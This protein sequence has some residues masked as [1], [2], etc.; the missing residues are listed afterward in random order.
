MEKLIDMHMHT[1]SSDGDYTADSLIKHAI[2][3]NVGTIAITDHDTI[4][5]LKSINKDNYDNIN[6]IDGIE[7]SCKI[8]KGSLHMLGYNIDINS[9]YLSNKIEMLNSYSFNNFIMLLA[10]IKKDY[11]LE[12]SYNDIMSILEKRKSI[13][14][15]DIARLCVKYGY[16]KTIQEGFDLYLKPA[17]KIIN[18]YRDNLIYEEAIDIIL[19]SGGIPVL[20]HPKTL[21][22]NEKELLLFVKKLITCGLQGIEVY[23]SSHNEEEMSLYLDI[24]K[25]YDLLISGGS[26]FH[27]TVKP[28]VKLGTGINNNLK[29]K[30]LSI[31]DYIK[32]CN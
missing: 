24:A 6:I 4:A 31:L 29:I 22:M 13:G 19:N 21:K 16:T 1:N 18:D 11:G 3:N 32:K 10:Q 9:E 7:L 20:A 23:H 30:Q 28:N 12:F 14:R 17:Y 25:K 8:D 27:G 5:G 26:D 15:P 2:D